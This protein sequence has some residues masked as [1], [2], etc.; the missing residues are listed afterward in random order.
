MKNKLWYFE[1]GTSETF[2]AT[3]KKLH[4]H[5]ELEVSEL[6]CGKA[7]PIVTVP[8]AVPYSP[9]GYVLLSLSEMTQSLAYVMWSILPSQVYTTSLRGLR[10]LFVTCASESL[11]F[12]NPY[13]HSPSD[14]QPCFSTERSKDCW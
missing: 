13:S 4:D 6:P 7:A 9:S 8:R 5:I 12:W 14:P 3:C 2:A 10:L 1:F 11:G